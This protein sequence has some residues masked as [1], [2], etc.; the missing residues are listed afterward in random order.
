MVLAVDAE[1]DW[2]NDAVQ[3]N[4][5]FG[6]LQQDPRWWGTLSQILDIAYAVTSFVVG[7]PGLPALRK[8]RLTDKPVEDCH[9]VQGW[10][11]PDPSVDRAGF[12]AA[13][14]TQNYVGRLAKIPGLL[15]PNY[16]P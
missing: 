5:T 15:R 11:A 13:A 4:K 6:V 16:F 8:I 7:R 1:S 10:K 14:E 2:N 12:Y 3:H 9:R